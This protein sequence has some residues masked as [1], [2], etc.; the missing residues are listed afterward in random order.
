MLELARFY[1]FAFGVFT[2]AG[3]IVGYVK[4]KSRA[5]LVAG[6]ISGAVLLLAAYLVGTAGSASTSQLALVV[7][8]VVS[9]ALAG[10][11]IGAYRK[12]KKVMPAGVMALLGVVGVVVTGAALLAR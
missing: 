10:R 9:L 1:L 6:G 7:G 8:M 5:S 4:A 3:G 11:F 12:S 2:I